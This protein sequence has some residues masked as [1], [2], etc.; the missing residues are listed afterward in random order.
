MSKLIISIYD[1]QILIDNVTLIKEFSDKIF[2]ININDK[3]YEITGCN[4]LLSHVS[5]N[6]QTIKIS[7]EILSVKLETNKPKEKER[8][9][10]KLFN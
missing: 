6:N 10:K 2:K 5:N 1:D 8:F 9:I 4:L 7:G 3:P